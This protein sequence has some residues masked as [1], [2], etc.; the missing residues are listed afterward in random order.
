V[1]FVLLS[2]VACCVSDSELLESVLA[3]GAVRYGTWRGQRPRPYFDDCRCQE[4]LDTIKIIASTGRLGLIVVD[5]RCERSML[6]AELQYLA[7]TTFIS[8]K[9]M[10][11]WII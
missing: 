2:C 10:C 1:H 11:F 3:L 9:S 5:L 6:I 8:R 4:R 7:R